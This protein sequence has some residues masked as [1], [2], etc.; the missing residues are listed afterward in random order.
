MFLSLISEPRSVSNARRFSTR[1]RLMSAA[2]V[3]LMSFALSGTSLGQ[4]RS[5]VA[6]PQTVTVAT[7]LNQFEMPSTSFSVSV[8]TQDTTGL[9]IISYD[10]NIFFD[11]SVVQ[12]QATPVSVTGTVSANGTVTTNEVTPGH[13]IISFFRATPL[14]GSGV[15]FNLQFTGIGAQG[16]TSPLTWGSFVYNE[17]TPGAS[18]TGGTIHLDLAPTAAPVTIAGF[19][20]SS[21]GEAVAN[22]VVRMT[23]R[24]GS[25]VSTRTNQFG[26]F[27][28]GDLSVGQSYILT[29]SAK[30]LT[31]SPRAMELLEDMTG[32]T[33]IANP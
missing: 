32:L 31:F 2:A 21:D 33:I 7:P 9:G 1:L 30:G 10:C 5:L 27:R 20:R 13:L 19:V 26:A 15:L 22:A 6:T 11:P 23:G 24:D 8:F 14:T 25:T 4:S 29:V 3:L 18:P 28:V 17:G 16:S 12:L